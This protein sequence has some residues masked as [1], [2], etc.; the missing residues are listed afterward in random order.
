M[1]RPRSSGT[2]QGS[3]VDIYTYPVW[4]GILKVARK[5]ILTNKRDVLIAAIR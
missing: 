2:T 1:R 3:Y 4:A 5:Q